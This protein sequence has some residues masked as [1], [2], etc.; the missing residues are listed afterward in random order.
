VLAAFEHPSAA[1]LQVCPF[2]AGGFRLIGG[3]QIGV[4]ARLA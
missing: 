2:D 1:I 4:A 3:D